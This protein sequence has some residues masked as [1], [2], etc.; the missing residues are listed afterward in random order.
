MSEDLPHT[1]LPWQAPHEF[2]ERMRGRSLVT[3][4]V[5]ERVL[6]C[7]GDPCPE[8]ASERKPGQSVVMMQRYRHPDS[9]VPP[10]FAPYYQAQWDVCGGCRHV[11]HHER[12]RRPTP[13]YR[14]QPPY[15]AHNKEEA[16]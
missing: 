6:V 8:C 12:F 16:A 1:D 3:G 7:E 2:N 10:P 11:S 15:L 9:F 5:I 14:P 4:V 13:N